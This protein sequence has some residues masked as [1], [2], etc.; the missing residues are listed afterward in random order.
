METPI[1][2]LA[3]GIYLDD[4]HL[5][6]NCREMCESLG[7]AYTPEN[8]QVIKAEA[9]LVFSEIFGKLPSDVS[10]FNFSGSVS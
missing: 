4:K 7:I 9:L 5:H 8:C 3:P 2:K 1:T 10:V 6:F